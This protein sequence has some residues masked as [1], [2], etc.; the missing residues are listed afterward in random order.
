M[1]QALESEVRKAAGLESAIEPIVVDEFALE[2]PCRSKSL[3][4]VFAGYILYA[5]RNNKI[6]LRE[7]WK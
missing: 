7:R 4:Y 3:V 2:K 1:V 5:W 6:A